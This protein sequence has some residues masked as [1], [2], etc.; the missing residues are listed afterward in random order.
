MSTT[1]LLARKL[2]QW[3]ETEAGAG[4]LSRR[5]LLLGGSLLA[6]LWS[7]RAQAAPRPSP[8]RWLVNRLTMGYTEAEHLLADSLGYYGYLE[9]H[10]NYTAIDDSALQARISPYFYLNMPSYVLLH[11]PAPIVSN[12]LIDATILRAVY[13]K[14][15]LFERMVEFWTDHFNIDI[16]TVLNIWLKLPDDRDVIRPNALG[17]YPNLLTASAQSASMMQYLGNYISITGNPNENYARELLELHNLG[18]DGGYTQQDVQ[19]VA[20]C[21]TGWGVSDSDP[22]EGAFTYRPTWHDNGP[23]VVLGYNIPA[24]GGFN[25]GL[26]VLDILVNHPST[27]KFIA[28]KLC[29]RFYSYSPP[30][31][32]ID[33]VA[34][35]F[36]ATG[37]DIKAMLRTLFT[38][39][40][41]A[42]APLKFKRPFHYFVSALRA[43]NA[44]IP[45]QPAAGGSAIRYRL[46]ENGHE[47]FHWPTPDGYHD[48]LEVWG[49]SL[50]PRWNFAAGLMHDEITGV[51]VDVNVFLGGATTADTIMDR[52]NQAFFGG[53][54][55]AAEITRIRDY[56]LPDVPPFERIREAIGLAISSPGFQWY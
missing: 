13:S 52:I 19:E 29:K 56:L 10:L 42:T 20:R 30:Q 4:N 16:N 22:N 17:M 33:S 5:N 11:A 24:G 7:T 27:A 36:T 47:P 35:T 23:K 41:P 6:S 51:T 34:A 28:K 48:S 26:I 38:S 50:L 15:Q 1:R 12:Q 55:A 39:I 8:S 37:G 54:M 25:D 3:V 40:D 9:Y 53:A 31:S 44:N 14:R 32:L 18:V 49:A 2:G 21:L 46:S 43:L 45:S